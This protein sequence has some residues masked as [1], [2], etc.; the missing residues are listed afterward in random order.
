MS[1]MSE[2]LRAERI[3]VPRQPLREIYFLILKMS[4]PRFLALVAFSFCALNAFFATLYWLGGD[5][6]TNAE[7]GSFFDAFAFS[8]QTLATIGYGKLLPQGTYANVVVLVESVVGVNFAALVTG[9]TFAKFSRP[10]THIV[11]TD[12][13]VVVPFEGVP[14]LMF[15]MG[16]GRDTNI[17]DAEVKVVTLRKQVSREGLVMSRFIDLPLERSTS[18]FFMLTWTVMH[19]LDKASPFYG[20][21]VEDFRQRGVELFISLVGF[22]ETYAQTVHA[23]WRY[24]PGDIHFAKK[25]VDVIETL[26]DGVRRIHFNRFHEIEI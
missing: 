15:R 7:P 14:T 25:F 17:M 12:K 2:R 23:N 13:V 16:N 3:G 20:F 5:T 18:S 10:T 8:N 9:L 4:W 6:I 11:F 21:S 24:T 1:R 26:P 22:D 19:K